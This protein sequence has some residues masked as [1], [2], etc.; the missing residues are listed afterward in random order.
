VPGSV[1][2][3]VPF[4]VL[5]TTL[6]RTFARSQGYPVIENDY[7]KGVSQRAVLAVNSR[8]AWRLAKQ[9]T[10]AQLQ[11]FRAF[12]EA[13]RGPL[14]PFYFYDPYEANPMFSHDPTGAAT[15]G[16]YTVRFDSEWGQTL[17]LGR[18]SV[19]IAVIELA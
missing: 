19:E 4:T 15:T 1:Q 10:T 3:G 11:Q 2:N 17:A 18:V 9:L 13:R 8:K 5:P 7:R 16:R 14:E 12:Y 6:C